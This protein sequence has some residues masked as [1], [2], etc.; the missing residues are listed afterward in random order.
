MCFQTKPYCCCTRKHIWNR[1][2]L[3]R[4]TVH[5][6]SIFRAW[7]VVIFC[8][9]WKWKYLSVNKWVISLQSSSL[10]NKIEILPKS[11]KDVTKLFRV[12]NQK[13]CLLHTRSLISNVIDFF[14][15]LKLFKTINRN[16]FD[17][18]DSLTIILRS[19]N[20]VYIVDPPPPT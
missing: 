2:K 1:S 19:V 13:P 7:L 9:T 18:G 15:D 17:F 4:I 3:S 16:C 10:P 11:S 20:Y 14:Y 8:Q 5:V 6:L 12:C